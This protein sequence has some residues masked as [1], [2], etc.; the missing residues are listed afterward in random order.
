MKIIGIIPGRGGSTGI[1]LKNIKKIA[2]KPLIGYSIDSALKSNKL[3]RV[4]V[5]TDNAAIAKISKKLGAE[6]PFLRPKNLSLNSTSLLSV[7]KHVEK[8]LIEKENYFP[9]IG[10]I[11]QPTSPFRTSEDIDKSISILKKS[12]ATSVVSI[13][14]TKNHPD[15]LFQFKNEL[16]LPLN[17]DFEKFFNRQKSSPVYNPTGLLYTF[18]FDTVKKYNSFYGPKIKPL[19]I[20]DK[21]KNID[22]DEI[23]EFF[24]AEMIMKFWHKYR[25]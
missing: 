3:D 8:F 21:L 11:L 18:Y 2:G 14:K 17:K 6:V 20:N 5:S 7:V 9:D 19:L 22:I 23:E 4:I 16:L 12:N 13:S 24:L 10:V 15:N 25:K 1:K